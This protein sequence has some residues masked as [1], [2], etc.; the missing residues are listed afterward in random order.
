MRSIES[1]ESKLKAKISS[2]QETINN[3]QNEKDDLEGELRKQIIELKSQKKSMKRALNEM[4][5]N[6][7]TEIEEITESYKKQISELEMLMKCT[8][9][10][11]E[12]KYAGLLTINKTLSQKSDEKNEEL[13]NK[14]EKIS[15]MLQDK[16]REISGLQKQIN[17][18]DQ[19][20]E[21]CKS[22]LENN[23]KQLSDALSK[24]DKIKK[25][26]KEFKLLFES[27]RNS[28]SQI[29][30]EITT[31]SNRISELETNLLASEQ[32]VANLTDSLNGSNK[33]KQKIEKKLRLSENTISKLENDVRTLETERNSMLDTMKSTGK[34]TEGDYSERESEYSIDEH[35]RKEAHFTNFVVCKVVKYDN[36]T[37]CLIFLKNQN[38]YNWHEKY[39]LREINSSIEIPDPYEEQLEERLA[40]QAEDI[41]EL[42]SI[43]LLVFPSEIKCEN[44]LEKIETLIKSFSSFRGPNSHPLKIF[45]YEEEVSSAPIINLN[46]L[47]TYSDNRS[48]NSVQVTAEEANEIFKKMKNLEE[49][50]MEL[51]NRIM[52]LNQ[53]L[54]HFKSEGRAGQFSG[55]SDA[56][57]EQIRE[58][59]LTMLDTLPLQS[60]ETEKNINIILEILNINK[61]YKENLYEKRE[62]MNPQGKKN[63][64]KNLFKKKK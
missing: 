1:S 2:F 15:D 63:P 3:L 6:K 62:E 61:D 16:N 47:E 49:E 18:K 64:F 50:N 41:K 58:V 44:L 17:I 42:N 38:Q 20:Y 46:P 29:Q 51:E 13:E 7:V 12:E 53:Q 30:Q 60:G 55:R 37:W 26:N 5:E 24:K 35:E 4:R 56:T 28:E 27:R 32:A 36:K 45:G 9:D 34:K 54:L 31:L 57:T 21:T 11:L 23:E 10:K 39:I 25:E 8:N 52:L 48:E 40:S 43:R 59:V 19:L 14:I 22:D 33:E